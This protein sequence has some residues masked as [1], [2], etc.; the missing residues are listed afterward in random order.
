MLLSAVSYC[1][2][3]LYRMEG[4]SDHT[5]PLN[6]YSLILAE[7]S[8]K[9]S[10]VMRFA[11]APFINF[12]NRYND[13]NMTEIYASQERKD[14]L[15]VQIDSMK[16]SGKSSPDEIAAMR[17]EYET[18]SPLSFRMVARRRTSFLQVSK[19]KDKKYIRQI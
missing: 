13:E 1:F 9:K 17:T 4:K 14:F 7:P 2:S 6:L 15:K 5:E 11:K 3:G 10:P 18:M 19:S 16:K 12:E 8:E